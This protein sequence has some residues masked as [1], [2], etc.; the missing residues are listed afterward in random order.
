VASGRQRR[1]EPATTAD[2]DAAAPDGNDRRDY[3]LAIAGDEVTM[4]HGSVMEL[5]RFAPAR[6]RRFRG[7]QGPP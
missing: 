6:Q 1:V 4:V 7:D 2:L 3:G 5:E